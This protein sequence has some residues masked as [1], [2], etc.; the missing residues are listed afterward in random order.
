MVCVQ[1]MD[2][3]GTSQTRDNAPNPPPFP[4]TLA[5]AIAALVN[6]TTLLAQNQNENQGRRGRNNGGET[7]YVDFTDTRPPVFSKADEPL[8]ANDWL[9]TMEQKFD[10]LQCT[11]YQKPVFAAQQLRDVAGAWWANLVAT[12]PTGHCITW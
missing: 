8:E 2:S 4:P 3:T 9:R 10:L 7:T 12:Q 11:E 5:K 6:A 1:Q